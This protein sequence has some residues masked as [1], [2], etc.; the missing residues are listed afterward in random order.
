MPEIIECPSCRRRLHAPESLLGQDVQCPSCGTNFTATF[1]QAPVRA[2]P[3][4]REAEQPRPRT[5]PPPDDYGLDAWRSSL[6]GRGS[7]RGPVLPHRGSAILTIGILAL[8]SLIVCVPSVIL[9]P[10]AWSMGSSDVALMRIG[11]MDRTGEGATIAGQTCGMIAT[12]LGI[13]GIV[14]ACL[15]IVS[16]TNFFSGRHRW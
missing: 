13:I 3:A 6:P 14:L 11:R 4:P 16:D 7:A 10:I 12:I 15:G 9:G 8:V 5:G 1:G 2:G